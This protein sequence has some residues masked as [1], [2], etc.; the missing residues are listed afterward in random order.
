MGKWVRSGTSP[1]KGSGDGPPKTEALSFSACLMPASRA[2]QRSFIKH[3][4]PIYGRYVV[5]M[6]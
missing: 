3:G 2:F 1:G 5:G 6:V 4:R